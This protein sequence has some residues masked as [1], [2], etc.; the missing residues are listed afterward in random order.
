MH[1]KK[2]VS[3]LMDIPENTIRNQ[4]TDIILAQPDP[5]P[6]NS[7]ENAEIKTDEILNVRKRQHER[8]TSCWTVARPVKGE[9]ALYQTMGVGHARAE[10]R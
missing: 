1:Q 6:R 3:V 9:G 2:K 5:R 10:G 4:S 7:S 8:H